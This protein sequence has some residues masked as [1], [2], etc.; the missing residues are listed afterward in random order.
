MAAPILIPVISLVA[1]S[2]AMLLWMYAT[3]LPAMRRAGMVPDNERVRGDQMAE[4]PARVRWKS[5]NYTHLTEH[6]TLFYAL[7][8][9]LALMGQGADGLN[10][11]LAWTYVGL[12]IVHSIWQAT[13]N[14][15]VARF[16]LFALSSL[17]CCALAIRALALAMS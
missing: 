11:A 7:A 1:W 4:L 5:D 6:P 12:R 17:V 16:I 3:R 2:H 9:S 15:I 8:I 10:L 14:Q 13:V